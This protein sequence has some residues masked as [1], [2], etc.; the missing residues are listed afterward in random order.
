MK[1]IFTILLSLCF[2][3][4]FAQAPQ[5]F[6]YQATVRDN[7]GQLVVNQNVYFKF[8]IMQNTPTSLPVYSEIHYA[9]TDDLG[10]VSLVIGHG[11]PET[12]T[13][14]GIDWSVGTYF[15]GIELNTGSGYLAMGTTQ[16]LSVPYALYANSAGNSEPQNLAEVLFQGNNGDGIQIKNIGYPTHENDAVTKSYVSLKVTETGD[17][18]FLGDLQWV[19]IPGISE[20]NWGGGEPPLN[21][22]IDYDGNIY[23]VITIGNRKWM[24]ANLKVTHYRNGESITY[25]GA[26]N[27]SWA[28][29]TNGAYAWYNNNI[30]W[31][32]I[33]GGLYNFYAVAN[34]NGLCPDGWHVP[35]SEEWSL[36]SNAIG[37]NESNSGNE[38]KSCRQVESPFEECATTI[39]PRWDYN[40]VNNG[41]D[42]HHFNAIPAGIRNTE[43]VFEG[44]GVMNG[45]WTSDELQAGRAMAR[46][47]QNSSGNIIIDDGYMKT[48]NS[49]RCVSFID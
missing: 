3:G 14:P 42:E 31:K 30:E 48:G 33:Y 40:E 47:L 16:F 4:V 26:E 44:L 38:L 23:P 12:G 10:N 9:P 49:V 45:L 8:N 5:G 28:A 37:G 41:T 36:L 32:H 13:F 24:A 21:T 29:N 39:H 15:L 11:T 27:S 1:K 7:N 22:V 34:S 25:P 17:T 6:N 35:N 20:A 43:G 19:I 2:T 18:L 46:I